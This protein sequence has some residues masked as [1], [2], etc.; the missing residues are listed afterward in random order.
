M[1]S[2]ARKVKRKQFVTARKTFMKNFKKTMMNFKKQ[3]K[4]SNCGREPIQGENIDN[5]HINQQSENID[6]I[7][8]ECYPLMAKEVQDV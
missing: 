7:C 3:V 1:G 4:C 2:F 5:W 6:L 8:P